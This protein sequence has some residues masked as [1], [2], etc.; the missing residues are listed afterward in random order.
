MC[1]WGYKPQANGQGG[2]NCVPGVSE[3]S[4][5]LA[6][7]STQEEIQSLIEFQEDSTRVVM[8]NVLGAMLWVAAAASA[9]TIGGVFACRRSRS[10]KAQA[11]FYGELLG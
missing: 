2:Y 3:I 1:K 9:I 11:D 4:L 8:L 5:A 7:N 6:G 10:S